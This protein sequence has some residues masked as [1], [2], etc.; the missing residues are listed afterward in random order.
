MT[1]STSASADAISFASPQSQALALWTFIKL[2]NPDF[3]SQAALGVVQRLSPQP[4]D[5]VKKLAKRLRAE[6]ATAGVSIKHVTALDAA[7]RMLSSQ[8]WFQRHSPAA[9]P[10]LFLRSVIN[11][12]EVSA[13]TWQELLPVLIRQCE[14]LVVAS[15]VRA[16]HVEVGE[17]MLTVNTLEHASGEK[18]LHVPIVLVIPNGDTD[19]WLDGAS[20]AIEGL[21]RR[22]EETQEAVVEGVA[23]L[24]LCS[25]PETDNA[26]FPPS[27]A[28]FA[29]LVLMRVDGDYQDGYEIARGNEFTCWSQFELACQKD[30][31]RSEDIW[32]TP[33]VNI[34][35]AAWMCRGGRY[36]WQLAKL[37]RNGTSAH[38]TIR[39]LD[40]KATRKLLKRYL[41]ARSRF[42]GRMEHFD[43]PK[44]FSHIGAPGENYRVDT[45]RLNDALANHGLTWDAYLAECGDDVPLTPELP[46]GFLLTLLER[47]NLDNP[48]S[49]LLA[50]SR[51]ELRR[52]DSDDLL[53]ALAPRTDHVRYRSSRRLDDELKGFVREAIQEFGDGMRTRML[54]TSGALQIE[55]RPL[56]NLVYAAEAEELRAGLAARGLAMY[57]GIMPNI[58]STKEHPN[59][60]QLPPFA[61]GTSLFIDVDLDESE[62]V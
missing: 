25:D 20:T 6:L 49:I 48:A 9:A 57:V 45:R 18:L 62:A 42:G 33:E 32:V 4:G 40:E 19:R 59:A 60:A 50:P 36:V 12:Q 1:A 27:A 22:F 23:P 43:L 13:M 7:S 52:V 55:G 56:P 3:N 47:L 15:H 8:G 21:R 54:M 17:K 58:V 35:D 24:Q 34:A 46:V 28:P 5:D 44:A 41:L 10:R 61:L 16:L 26:S 38:L 14:P 2:K 11:D 29:E 37:S 39:E 53:R 51:A 30:S 31:D